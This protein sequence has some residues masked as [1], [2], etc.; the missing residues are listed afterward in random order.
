M[1]LTLATGVR[2]RGRGNGTYE[3]WPF[4]PKEVV[5]RCSGCLA[6]LW[7]VMGRVPAPPLSELETCTKK[8][9]RSRKSIGHWTS[10]TSQ[11]PPPNDRTDCCLG[12]SSS[13]VDSN[14]L[15]L[16][17]FC[18]LQEKSSDGCHIC[19]TPTPNRL[20]WTKIC[21][22]R[23]SINRQCSLLDVYPTI[24]LLAGFQSLSAKCSL[25]SMI[26]IDAD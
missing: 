25:L 21:R 5:T 13:E 20:F 15:L 10:S 9:L 18:F 22:Y 24:I 19:A 1:S 2:E 16:L 7:A 12:L 11:C 26:S 3:A 14:R 6:R 4:H 8:L 17:R 23:L